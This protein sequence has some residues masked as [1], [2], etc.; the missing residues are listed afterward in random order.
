MKI[1]VL[2]T[3]GIGADIIDLFQR[4]IKISGV[5]GLSNRERTDAISDYVYMADFCQSKGIEFIE[6]N[7]YGLSDEGD[8][9]RITQQDIDVLIVAGWQRLIP[10]WLI[11]HCSICA[12]GAHGSPLG[13]TKGRGARLRTGP[14]YSA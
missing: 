12:I 13:I 10:G 14:L 4:Q 5:I 3:L 8:K 9:K 1:F 7:H 6:V 11:K 2:S